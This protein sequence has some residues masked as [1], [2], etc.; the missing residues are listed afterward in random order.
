MLDQLS[1]ELIN[2]LWAQIQTC[3][4]KL[5][6]DHPPFSINVKKKHL[7]FGF[8]VNSLFSLD[9]EKL[10]P[11]FYSRFS[12]ALLRLMFVFLNGMGRAGRWI[13]FVV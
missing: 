7:S 11:L 4:L 8:D 12:A 3:N 1:N 9:G 10:I 6:T 5:T 13:Y 2:L